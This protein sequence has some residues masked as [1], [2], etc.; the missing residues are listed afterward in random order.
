MGKGG[1]TWR[2]QIELARAAG[3]AAIDVDLRAARTIEAEEMLEALA[4]M[5]ASSGRLPVYPGENLEPG[6]VEFCRRIGLKT[7]TC[8]VPPSL[9]EA[10]NLVPGYR[11]WAE[12]LGGRG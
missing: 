5:V 2:E 4:G 10:R 9:D 7:L 1:E 12:R 6:V 8:S 11:E 3:F